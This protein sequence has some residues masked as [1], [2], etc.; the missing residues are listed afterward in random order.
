MP[1]EVRYDFFQI[2]KLE[3]IVFFVRCRGTYVP[4]DRTMSQVVIIFDIQT[5]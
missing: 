5:L 3:S 2:D 4:K 1:F